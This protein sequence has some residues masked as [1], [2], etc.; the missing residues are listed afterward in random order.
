MTVTVRKMANILEVYPCGAC[1]DLL[2][3]HLTQGRRIR[4]EDNRYTVQREALYT[5][6]PEQDVLRTY[7]GFLN[8]VV[9]F[10]ER[11]GVSYQA[12]EPVQI[13]RKDANLSALRNF[14]LRGGQMRMLASMLNYERGQY[15]GFTAMGKSHLIRGYVLA[16]PRSNIAVMAQ[17]KPVAFGLHRELCKLI[18]EEEVGM[19]GG[20]M[21]RPNRVTV[22]TAKSALKPGP[23]FIN[24]LDTL[25]YDEVHTAGAPD[26]SEKLVEYR[27]CRMFGFSASTECRS[28]GADLVVE[29]LFGPVRE[30]VT[31]Q[32]GRDEGYAADVKAYFYRCVAKQSMAFR[33][34][35]RIRET[36]W[37][38]RIRNDLIARM[39]RD[40]ERR[41]ENPQILIMVAT[42]EHACALGM[43]LPEYQIVYASADA[44]KLERLHR[45]KLIPPQFRRYTP[46]ERQVMDVAI[47]NGEVKR[48]IATTTLGTGVD[49]RHLDVFIRADGGSSEVSNI[50]FRGRVARGKKGIYLDVYDFGDGSP[51]E[52]DDDEKQ[53]PRERAA[54]KR[55]ASCKKEGWEPEM[56]VL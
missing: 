49:L 43:L 54:R 17:Q 30:T 56:V 18:G 2:G 29:G 1:V 34:T 8:R 10:F 33:D 7:A 22:I 28:D 27:V 15:N 48:V 23:Q 19:V 53:G 14:P 36:V 50:Q 44:K 16:H 4:G 32:E 45:S 6:D 31:M 11:L 37:R 13:P 40:W 51:F 41:M 12:V 9:E 35:D 21:N 24:S 38:N 55:M 5:Y 46:T 3:H 39:A 52:G 26:I 20:G 47:E 25:L 42:L